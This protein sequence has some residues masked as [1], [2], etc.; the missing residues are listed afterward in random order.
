M[1]GNRYYRCNP[2]ICLVH[3]AASPG[4]HFANTMLH[5]RTHVCSHLL[6]QPPHLPATSKLLP[7]VHPLPTNVHC[8]PRM[9][10]KTN[11]CPPLPPAAQTLTDCNTDTHR[12][13][14]ALTCQLQLNHTKL[15]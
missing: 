6:S 11:H 7:V 1:I 8:L 5:A 13:P 4:L 14:P 9:I 3:D 15:P 10:P 12:L 2:T